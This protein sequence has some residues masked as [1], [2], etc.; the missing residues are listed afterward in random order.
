MLPVTERQQSV[1][2]TLIQ[3][4]IQTG[5]AVSSGAI[6]SAPHIQVSSATVRSVLS[7]L[8]GLGLLEKPHTSAGRVPTAH[9]MRLYVNALQSSPMP[10]PGGLLELEELRT[11]TFEE[12]VQTMGSVL[13]Q[14]ARLASVISFSGLGGVRLKDLHLSKVGDGRVLVVMTTD[15][16]QVT[17]C[18]VRLEGALEPGALEKMRKYL[19]ELAEGLTLEQV[20]MRVRMELEQAERAYADF[21][22]QALRIGKEALSLRPRVLVEGT[23]SLFDYAEFTHDVEHLR[24]L[25][26]VLEER[27]VMLELLDGLCHLDRDPEVFIGREL[28]WD[29]EDVSVVL[30]CYGRQGEVAGVLGLLG[31]MRIDYER[32]IPL[33]GHS[34]DLLSRALDGS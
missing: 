32:I 5:H 1:L 22:R 14:A 28:S 6:T 17:H 8:E 9:G 19:L 15:D 23:L 21:I 7:E 31:P 4:F 2:F 20:R 11:S 33:V 18:V 13:S 26:G 34:A 29:F 25:L 12:T 27:E 16:R 3:R 24:E 30:C 10:E